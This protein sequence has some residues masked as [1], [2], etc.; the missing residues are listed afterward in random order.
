MTGIDNEDDGVSV[1]IVGEGSTVTDESTLLPLTSSN[2]RNDK[3]ENGASAPIAGPTINELLM[4]PPLPEPNVQLMRRQM[5]GGTS[6]VL[7]VVL[8]IISVTQGVTLTI[9]ELPPAA[10]WTV[11]VVTYTEA[12]IALLCLTGLVYGDPG[13]VQRTPENCFPL[14]PEIEYALRNPEAY[15]NLPPQTIQMANGDIFCVRC[16]VWRRKQQPPPQNGPATAS[17]SS[18]SGDASSSHRLCCTPTRVIHCYICN[19]CVRDF[20]HHCVVFGRCIAGV[21]MAGN[22]KYFMT[23][24]VIGGTAGLI[25]SLSLV[26]S[27]VLRFSISL[28]VLFIIIATLFWLVVACGNRFFMNMFAPYRWMGIEV[29]QC[30]QWCSTGM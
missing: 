28:W 23:L 15:E 22:M 26:A 9:G 21:G 19:R 11:L 3:E 27:L 29:L 30:F 24:L 16:M 6:F 17:S 5:A 10:W 20:D 18:R 12:V 7:L 14:P 2:I 4:L 1:P 25:S 13:V 8:L